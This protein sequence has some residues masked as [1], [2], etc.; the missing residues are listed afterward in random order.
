MGN[1]P[2]GGST[3]PGSVS[4]R[5][6]GASSSSWPDDIYRV[7]SPNSE[8]RNATS[9]GSTPGTKNVS[10]SPLTGTTTAAAAT[11][12]ATSASSPNQLLRSLQESLLST[13]S[14]QTV[15]MLSKG[16]DLCLRG[17]RAI[18]KIQLLQQV[19]YGPELRQFEGCVDVL[20][21]LV[22]EL[23]E[24]QKKKFQLPE[25][26]WANPGLSLF[27][28]VNFL[29]FRCKV[30]QY[31]AD[32]AEVVWEL[33]LHFPT[34]AETVAS[35]RMPSLSLLQF[36]SL[37]KIG[38]EVSIIN[39]LNE[40][41]IS[42]VRFYHLIKH[43]GKHLAFGACEQTKLNKTRLEN[44]VWLL[45][46]G[47]DVELC[48]PVANQLVK[49]CLVEYCSKNQNYSATTAPG[50][51]GRSATGAA[52]TDDLGSFF[53][54]KGLLSNGHLL[55]HFCDG[56]LSLTATT[57]EDFDCSLA[58]S[59]LKTVVEQVDTF[60]ETN[61]TSIAPTP[62]SGAAAFLQSSPQPTIAGANAR[63]GNSSSSL[64]ALLRQERARSYL[65]ISAD[66]Q[67]RV[68]K[69]AN[70]QEVHSESTL[71][72]PKSQNKMFISPPF[73]LS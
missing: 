22:Q 35:S 39:C 14:R 21:R 71:L 3:L 54:E 10:A 34:I 52:D 5:P 31:L 50:G 27:A 72:P 1:S 12:S 43:L 24:K 46:F 47:V 45:R 17:H 13:Q 61:T 37:H 42:L 62:T 8:R 67:R 51:R 16:S 53:W 28:K 19:L 36:A 49:Q 70:E 68:N 9:S 38:S 66:Q 15:G 63:G 44:L 73:K 59:D 60:G 2:P 65:K 48:K 30:L 7:A 11:A 29:H 20:E 56:A 25:D 41:Q 58:E 55:N 18:S 6:G 23:S 32:D 26:Q 57:F 64:A 69:N 33:L 40:K 4:S